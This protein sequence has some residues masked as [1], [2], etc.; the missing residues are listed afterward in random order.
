MF[1]HFCEVSVFWNWIFTLFWAK[2]DTA[3]QKTRVFWLLFVPE[4]QKKALKIE[5]LEN[6][7]SSFLKKIE[8]LG[9]SANRVSAKMLKKTPL[10]W[11]LSCCHK[12]A[13]GKVG[14]THK[15]FTWLLFSLKP[16]LGS[17]KKKGKD[18]YEFVQFVNQIKQ[19]PLDISK[20]TKWK[21]KVGWWCHC[22]DFQKIH[23]AAGLVWFQ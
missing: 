22:F 23:F 14:Q 5:F 4:W 17:Y 13:K 3:C 20:I 8:F 2:I 21:W 12:G 18:C 19:C 15:N 6:Q 11:L 16:N 9:F 1:S 10:R 7:K